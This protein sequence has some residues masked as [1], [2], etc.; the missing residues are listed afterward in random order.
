M[1][2]KVVLNGSRVLTFET[3]CDKMEAVQA[4]GA[5]KAHT[6]TLSTASEGKKVLQGK[7]STSISL[8]P[9][10]KPRKTIPRFFTKITS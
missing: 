2:I 10:K 5:S 6:Q 7:S 1:R 3:K 8:I 9:Y 4:L